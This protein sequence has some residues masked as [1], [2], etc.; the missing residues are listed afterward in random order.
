MQLTATLA[1]LNCQ[2]VLDN[3]ARFVTSPT[4][5][6][7]IAV[8]NNG[9]VTVTDQTAIGGA[10]TY[11]PTMSAL[12]QIGGF[13][14]FSLFVTPSASRN[15]TE[16][17]SMVPVTDVDKLRRVRC[18]FQLLV[19]GGAESPEFADCRKKIEEFY[20]NDAQ[21]VEHAIP[22]GWYNVGCEKDVPKDA[23][24]VG[25]YHG[26]YV[27]IM[28]DGIDGL[29]R[30]TMTVMDLAASA[31]EVPTKTVLRKYDREGVLQGT[32]TTT[33][34]VIIDATGKMKKIKGSTQLQ[35]EAPNVDLTPDIPN[36][37]PLTPK[38][39]ALTPKQARKRAGASVGLFPQAQ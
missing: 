22:I 36:P 32:E 5:L 30:F 29:S 26:T 14:I 39:T 21:A 9:T 17:W 25:C 24:L 27:W 15:V 35:A 7:S 19:S 33:K 20:S 11:S 6:P 12:Q 37:S 23:C 28:A 18:A 38:D 1:D 4:S 8:V 16:N 10:G 13:P 31:H 3:I 2:Q 34:E